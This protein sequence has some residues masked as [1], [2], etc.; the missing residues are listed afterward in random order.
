[1]QELKY[2]RPATVDEAVGLLRNGGNAR[3]LAG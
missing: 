2:A 3:I 1:L